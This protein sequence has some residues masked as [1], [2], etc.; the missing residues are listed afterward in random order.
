MAEKLRNVVVFTWDGPVVVQ[1]LGRADPDPS[2]E[3]LAQLAADW[4]SRAGGVLPVVRIIETMPSMRARG[5]GAA[6]GPA[7]SMPGR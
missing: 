2:L 3:E 6:G 1:R 7:G 5:V 4:S